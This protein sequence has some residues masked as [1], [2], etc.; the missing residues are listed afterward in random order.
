MYEYIGLSINPAAK[1][2]SVN[3]MQ[4]DTNELD[5]E[6]HIQPIKNGILHTI[7]DFFRPNGSNKLVIDAPTTKHKGTILAEMEK[8]L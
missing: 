5:C 1:P 8:T 2:K 7:I 4:I 6:S 3:D